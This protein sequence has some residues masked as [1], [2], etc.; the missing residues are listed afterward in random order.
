ME[1]TGI[2]D[3]GIRDAQMSSEVRTRISRFVGGKPAYLG[4][5]GPL[6][7]MLLFN[8]VRAELGKPSKAQ[9]KEGRVRE[10]LC[11]AVPIVYVTLLSNIPYLGHNKLRPT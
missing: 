1:G 4:N 9:R 5:K 10:A 7:L 11:R 6:P 2:G 3:A 8:R